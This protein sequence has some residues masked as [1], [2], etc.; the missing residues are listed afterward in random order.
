MS[1]LGSLLLIPFLA[2]WIATHDPYLTSEQQFILPNV[3]HRFETTIGRDL[4]SRFLW[5]GQRTILVGLS[6]T[7]DRDWDGNVLVGV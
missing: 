6:S 2:P 1:G 7:P 3:S 4:Y 5:G